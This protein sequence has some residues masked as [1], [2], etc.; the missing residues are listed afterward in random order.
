MGYIYIPG[1]V[2]VDITLDDYEK[3]ALDFVNQWDFTLGG[4]MFPDKKSL[5]DAINDAAFLD[6]ADVTF[7]DGN[8]RFSVMVDNDNNPPSHKQVEAWKRGEEKLYI[9]D[10]FMSAMFIPDLPQ[11]MTEEQAKSFGIEVE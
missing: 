5:I 8:I 6:V 4:Q 10:G 11:D 9:A 1:K 7:Y 3:G 2:F